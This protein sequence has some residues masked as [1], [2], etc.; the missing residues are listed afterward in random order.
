MLKSLNNFY[1]KCMI[2]LIISLIIIG[3]LVTPCTVLAFEGKPETIKVGFFAFDGYHEMDETGQKSGYGYDFLTLMRRYSDVNY[4]YI[5][6]DKSWSD[7]QQM[8]LDGDIDMVTSAHKNEEREKYFDFSLPIGTNAINLNVRVDEKRYSAGD[9]DTYDGMTIGLIEGSSSNDRIASFAAEKGFSFDSRYYSDSDALKEALH[10]GE[11]DAVATSSLRRIEDELILEE[12]NTEYFYAIVRKGDNALLEKINYAIKQ[13]NCNEGDW[14]NSLYYDNYL[15]HKHTDLHFTDEEKAFISNYSSGTDKLVIA[16]DT[17]WIPFSWKKNDEYTGIIVDIVDFCMKKCGMDYVI[18]DSDKEI[19]NADVLLDDYVDLYIGYSNSDETAEKEGYVISDP[20]LNCGS[21]YLVLKETNDI[22]SIA[23]CDTT[24]YLNS[25]LEADDSII[26]KNYKDTQAAKKAVINKEVDAAYLYDY[27]AEY[28]ANHDLSGRLAFE[29]I[30]GGDVKIKAAIRSN[31]DRTLLGIWMKCMNSMTEAEKTAIVSKYISHTATSMTIKDYAILHPFTFLGSILLVVIILAVAVFAWI[32]NIE[33]KKHGAVLSEKVEE[34][35][36]LNDQLQENQARLEESAT[37]QEAQL[38]EITALN[39]ELE[40]RQAQLEESV[41]EQEAQI[42][43]VN[44]LNEELQR[45][46]QELSQANNTQKVHL[47]E[48]ERLNELFKETQNH[49][50]RSLLDNV[51]QRDGDSA[52]INHLVQTV[53]E[54]YRADR[55]YVF[56]RDITGQY[57]VNTYEWC[58]KGVRPEIDNLQ[59]IPI[60]VVD[61]WIDEFRKKGSFFIS[62]DDEYAKKEPM[63]YE[64][65]EPQGI[66]S[67][68]AAPMIVNGDIIG[69]IGVDN[70]KENLEHELYLAVAATAINH[71]NQIILEKER[72]EEYRRELEIARD[73]AE[74][75]NEAKTTFLFSMS[76]DIRTPMNAIIGY[77]ELMERYFNDQDRCR[78]YLEKIRNSSDIL[79]SLINNVL[80]MARIESGKTVIKESPSSV[81]DIGNNVGNVFEELMRDKNIAFSLTNHFKTPYIYIDKVKVNEIYVNLISNAY[82]YTPEGGTVTVDVREKPSEKENE[83]LVEVTVSD[84]GIGMSKE[85]LPHIFDE[86]SREYTSTESRIQGTGLG[87]PIVKKLVDLMNGTIIVESEPGKGTTFVVTLPHRIADEL[88]IYD[89]SREIRPEEFVG[90]RILLA[91]DNDFNAE[92]A[93]ELL[94]EAG[95]IVERAEDGMICVDKLSG[96]ENGYYDLILMDIQ[97]PNMDGYKATQVIR[98]MENSNK[99]NIPIIAMTANAFEEDRLKAIRAGM[100]GHIAKPVNIENLFKSISEVFQK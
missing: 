41:S 29:L 2:S 24:P 60:H 28:S 32:K 50:I 64:V 55:A 38:E 88:E 95:F 97:M 79:L 75:A 90:K 52:L 47:A 87:M 15:S 98:S 100:D 89:Y 14:K 48:I 3:P 8:L 67:L 96:S 10:N 12:F 62:C 91:E 49:G 73:A 54:Y 37:E 76:H 74:V 17:D 80:E 27:D 53:G 35:T 58:A 81:L 11:V 43:E 70:P 22:K 57:T 33:E 42:E 36:A 71:E 34:I 68:M 25:R 19:C 39:S 45:Q 82:K 21:A 5:G 99:R 30:S 83:I 26:L 16:T 56:E 1:N 93:V 78:K 77:A 59:N 84:T 6:Y 63:V 61:P 40:E 46:Q 13:M 86:F 65:L 92:I 44:S 85:F 66:T 7:M 31:E 18:Y 4:E 51:I 23:I 9:Y 69:F 72:E 94:N 20:V